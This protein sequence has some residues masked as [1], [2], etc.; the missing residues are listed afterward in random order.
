MECIFLIVLTFTQYTSLAPRV[1]PSG[2]S[3]VGML[4]ELPLNC[5]RGDYNSYIY[6]VTVQV[7][8]AL[9]VEA[10]LEVFKY[11]R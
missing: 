9:N 2:V 1:S 10:I 6:Q 5:L 11:G 8:E 7:V 3:Y 4:S